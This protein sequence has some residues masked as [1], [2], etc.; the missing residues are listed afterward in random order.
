VITLSIRVKHF[1][2]GSRWNMIVPTPNA[3]IVH[4]WG[5]VYVILILKA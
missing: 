1:S 2:G 4:M 5:G 3:G